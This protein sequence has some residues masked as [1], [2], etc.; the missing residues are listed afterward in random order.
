MDEEKNNCI[1]MFFKCR[2]R[3]CGEI[4]ETTSSKCECGANLC[5]DCACDHDELVCCKE[6]YNKL[7]N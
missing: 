2:C 5:Y 4:I 7:N 1:K 3:D 6:C